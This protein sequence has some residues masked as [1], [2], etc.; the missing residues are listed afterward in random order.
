MIL[1]NEQQLKDALS[2]PSA[3]DI[4]AVARLDGDVVVLGAGGK[5]GPSLVR[6][7]RRAADA[8]GWRHYLYAVT[9]TAQDWGAGIM[10]LGVDLLDRRQ[11]DAL[12]DA[13]HVIYM[14]GRKFGSTGNEGLTWAANT[15][16]PALAAERYAGSRIVAFSTGNVYPLVPVASGGAT[17]AT[18]PDPVGEYA[19]SALGRER[20]FEHFATRHNTPVLLLR[21]NY[22]VEPRYGV[23][24]DI[25]TRVFHGQPVPLAMG[26]VNVI[27]QGDANSACLRG[28]PLCASPA[29][30]LNLTGPETLSVRALAEQFG[31]HFGVRPTV[32]GEEAPTALLN[33]AAECHRQLGPPS[34]SV[35]ELIEMIAH[36]I[37]TGGRTLAKPTH[38]ETRSGRF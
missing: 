11:V 13:A 28:F 4:E 2:Q 31:Q 9:R 38:F 34:V 6:R 26:H 20:I 12:P 3:E 21:L 10:G 24:L 32:T 16:A 22:A 8:A 5:M 18:P 33:N 29:R 30:V 7:F 17:E 27:W 37:Q 15:Y 19:Q 36:W 25:G 23:L 35:D 14:V 1:D